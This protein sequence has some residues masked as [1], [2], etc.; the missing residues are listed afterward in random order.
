MKRSDLE[1]F[2]MNVIQYARYDVDYDD[3]K[4]NQYYANKIIDGILKYNYMIPPYFK[5]DGNIVDIKSYIN[6]D[7]IWEPE[8]E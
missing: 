3:T 6:E 1:N 8:D 7:F 2:I 4:P 5:D